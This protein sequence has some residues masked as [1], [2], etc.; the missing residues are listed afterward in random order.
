[1]LHDKYEDVDVH[2][3]VAIQP[4]DLFTSLVDVAPPLPPQRILTGPVTLQ[5]ADIDQFFLYKDRTAVI[6]ISWER[7]G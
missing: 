1:M 2:K 3:T 4:T 7:Q 5:T 6:V